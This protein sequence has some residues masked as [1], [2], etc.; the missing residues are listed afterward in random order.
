MESVLQKAFEALGWMWPSL[1]EGP[2]WVGLSPVSFVQLGAVMAGQ[3]GMDSPLLLRT[4]IS[5]NSRT[6]QLQHATSSFKQAAYIR[7]R[8]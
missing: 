6:R 2:G 4:S 3:Q 1:S 5:S 8:G 7:S